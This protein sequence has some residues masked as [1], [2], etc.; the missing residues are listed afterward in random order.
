MNFSGRNRGF[1]G[2]GL[3]I[4]PGGLSP[5]IRVIII[6]CAGVFLLQILLKSG[7]L[8][9]TFGLSPARFFDDF[10]NR[11]YQLVTYMF[12]HGGFWHIFFNMFGL[13]MFGTEIEYAWGS[14]RF[15]RFYFLCGL[16]GAV[17]TL[18]VQSSQVVPM[19]GASA[20]IYGVLVA[21]WKM[22]PEREIYLYFL[23]PVKVK[24]F[25][26]GFMLLGF[27]TAAPGIAH[28]A[29][30]GGAVF[31]F[32]YVKGDWRW[33]SLGRKLKNLRYKRQEAKLEKRRQEAEDVMKR[34]DAILDK[35]NEVGID[36]ISREDRKFLEEASSRLSRKNNNQ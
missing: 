7:N 14:K 26:P 28:W 33:M 35:I 5:F 34:V 1:G 36:N 3:R 27:L 20:A 6:S 32:V 29:H 23:F 13:W 8:A 18:A 12:L 25:V 10:P 11:I 19:I 31:A 30:L 22:F 17:L 24:W 2:T 16:A 4:G 9:Y 21:Y 15:G